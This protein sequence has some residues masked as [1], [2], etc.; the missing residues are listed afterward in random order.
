MSVE[1]INHYKKTVKLA[2]CDEKTEAGFKKFQANRGRSTAIYSLSALAV[3][4]LA[5]AF[6]EYWILGLNSSIPLFSYLF[7]AVLSV[8]LVLYSMLSSSTTALKLRILVPGM[9]TLAVMLLGIYL[10]NYRLYHA[11]EITLLVLWLGSLNILSFRL[12][13]VLSLL[14]ISVFSGVSFISGATGIKISGLL[15]LMFAAYFLALYLS[16]IMERFRRMMFLTRETLN[17][18]Y[19]RQENW[20]YTLID[21]DMALSGIQ[22]FKAVIA[23]LMEHIKTVI[24]YDSFVSTSLNGKGNKPE[25]DQKDGTLFE[26]EDNTLWPD[27]LLTRLSQTRQA[28]VSSQY[29]EAKGLLGKGKKKFLH[30]R[31][32]IP[33]INDSSLIGVVSLRRK[34]E[35]FDDLDMTAGVS[36]STQAMM[37][38]NRT[39]KAKTP[40]LMSAGLQKGV[41]PKKATINVAAKPVAGNRKANKAVS[42]VATKQV[43]SQ[44]AAKPQ[45]KP[46]PKQPVQQTIQQ[47]VTKESGPISSD[48]D[49]II[50]QTNFEIPKKSTKG[51]DETVV[52]SAVIQKI[53]QNE[54][55]ARKTITLLSRE[56]AEH[57]S[58]DR[59]RTAAVEGEPLSLL[60]VEVDGLPSIREKE[61]DQAALKV[62]S[63]IIKYVFS[64][65]DK[66][67]DV[68]G[69]YGQNGFSI[70]L[71]RVDMNA[72]ENF[73][74]KL[75]HHTEEL[76][77]K[78]PG[79]DGR[80]TLS[81]GVASIT[82][83]TGNHDSMV[84]RADMALFVAKKNGRNCV[85]VRL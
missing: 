16:Y 49:M 55:S 60:L 78:A 73:A 48:V 67:S 42:K 43:I 74:E 35:A 6:L 24:D 58:M 76:N 31:L 22:D 84:K 85:K 9:M 63:R 81:I 72:A 46:Q 82:D 47:N 12:S 52:P 25:A 17:D 79:G 32:D 34:S 3:I 37:I 11:I 21:L 53:K 62:F 71:I 23:R 66:D 68:L 77:V 57:V 39:V 70:L 18:V 14:T 54:A 59:Y 64:K 13:A 38:F 41:A 44:I 20:A 2:F 26:Q 5:F 4:N 29:E 28:S 83:E 65:T 33:I 69:R 51:R 8:L 7:I 36:L 19:R 30:Y 45:P 50:E 27:D 75:R 61:G 10:Q 80:V 40:P 1:K 15:A 56:N